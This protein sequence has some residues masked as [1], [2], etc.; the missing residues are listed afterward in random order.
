M[1]VLELLVEPPNT[2]HSISFRGQ[3]EL[4]FWNQVDDLVVW[5]E[6]P[7][8]EVNSADLQTVTL[9]YPTQPWVN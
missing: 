3:F 4:R 1:F 9:M 5:Q 6:V 7:R 2:P 8:I